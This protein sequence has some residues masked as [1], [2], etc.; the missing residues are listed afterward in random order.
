MSSPCCDIPAPADPVN[1]APNEIILYGVR[2]NYAP[3][4]PP[5]II[6]GERP[7]PP[8]TYHLQLTVTQN[9]NAVPPNQVVIGSMIAYAFEGHCYRFDRPK[10]M[11]FPYDLPDAPAQGC[12]FELPNPVPNPLPPAAYRMWRIHTKTQIV[13][14]DTRSDLAEALILEANLPGR[15]AV[16]TYSL[17]MQMAHRGGRITKG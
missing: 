10:V 17:D 13:E 16:N 14:L 6:I 9:G 15:R 5:R 7:F 8:T 3:N 4:I 12:G 1:Y 11:A 2:L